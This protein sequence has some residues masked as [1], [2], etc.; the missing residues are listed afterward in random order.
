MWRLEVSED[1][2]SWT[3]ADERSTVQP[4][5]PDIRNLTVFIHFGAVF[6]RF[7]FRT[8]R[9]RI[10]SFGSPEEASWYPLRKANELWEWAD[11]VL[12]SHRSQKTGLDAR[13]SWLFG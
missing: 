8:Y 5:P 11:R 12:P 9:R 3:L 10:A 4:V 6:R 13:L 1:Q 2:Q 7:P